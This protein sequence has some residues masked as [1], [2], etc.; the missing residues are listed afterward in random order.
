MPYHERVVPP[1]LIFVLICALAASF[2]LIL[3]PLSPA[4]ATVVAL[5][6]GVLAGLVQYLT[7][8]VIEVEDGWFRAGGAQIEG[9]FL[10]KVE[11]LDREGMRRTMG[12]DADTR[13]YTAYRD[14]TQRGVKVELVDPRDPAPYWLVSS[15]H[16]EDLAGALHA[17]S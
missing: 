8:P 14:H 13:A 15:R 5:T 16:P 17:I 11:V 10:G 3:V 7:S 1:P 4:L 12:T 6:L 9:H 2:G